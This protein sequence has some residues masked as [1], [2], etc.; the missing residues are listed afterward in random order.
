MEHTG[1][2]ISEIV[3]AG[4]FMPWLKFW[5]QGKAGE[6]AGLDHSLLFKR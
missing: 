4:Q 5:S 3:Q 2:W 1:E 6:S